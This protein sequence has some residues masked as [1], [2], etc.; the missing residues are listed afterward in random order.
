[1]AE[2]NKVGYST[3]ILGTV[4]SVMSCLGIILYDKYD[5]SGKS[6]KYRKISLY[7]ITDIF[8]IVKST[9]KY[10]EI[11]RE[12][13]EGDFKYLHAN[14]RIEGFNTIIYLSP[15]NGSP[16]GY[17]EFK[18][19]QGIGRDT[20]ILLN[21][22]ASVEDFDVILNNTLENAENAEKK[23]VGTGLGDYTSNKVAWKAAFQT[24]RG[25]KHYTKFLDQAKQTQDSI[26]LDSGVVTML[27]DTGD[28]GFMKLGIERN[29][30]Y[31]PLGYEFKNFT[32]SNYGN[33]IVLTTWNGT[34]YCVTSLTQKNRFNE[35]I[36]Y[37]K[38]STGYFTLPEEDDYT[39][40]ITHAAGKYIVC[41]STGQGK[42]INRAYNIETREWEKSTYNNVFVDPLDKS[43]KLYDIPSTFIMTLIYKYMPELA[44]AYYT[45]R[46]GEYVKLIRKIG[47]WFILNVIRNQKSVYLV[48][49]VNYSLYITP[50]QLT[51]LIFYDDN[52][53][54][55]N[56]PNH[57]RLYTGD[58]VERY[59]EEAKNLIGNINSNAS[60][61]VIMKSSSI[62]SS[63]FND[64]RRG[65]FIDYSGLPEFVAGYRGHLFYVNKNKQTINF[66]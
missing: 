3:H 56:T 43:N 16:I 9:N 41:N 60:P 61:E 27:S 8:D 42:S 15:I 53:I 24:E 63:R 6:N 20:N 40:T 22:K 64:L 5:I 34:N 57:Y 62:H 12:N 49:G 45:F 48:A 7:N 25:Q 59:T 28:L 4:K 30:N 35:L 51:D 65:A 52:L 50:E 13:T 14:G 32:I 10:L 47:N 66:L 23:Y 58:R 18:N 11:T 54:I 36:R 21:L 44:N 2:I 19:T 46:D 37:T 1:M 26:F 31:S 39:N 38:S 33:D 17:T 29:M 55:L